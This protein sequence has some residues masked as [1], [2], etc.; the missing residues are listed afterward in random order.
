MIKSGFVTQLAADTT[1]P[2]NAQFDLGEGVEAKRW[3]FGAASNATNDAV[4]A[5]SFD[6]TNDHAFVVQGAINETHNRARKV[7][8]RTVAA[9]GNHVVAV[10][11]EDS[12][13]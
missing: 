9:T 7:W 8:V 10:Q 11:A 1:Y 4:Y 5:I 2:T 12:A 3:L 6:G 13:W